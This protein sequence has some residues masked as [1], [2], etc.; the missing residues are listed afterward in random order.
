MSCTN[1][2]EGR[3]RLEG[4]EASPVAQSVHAQG[5]A[6]QIQMDLNE[7]EKPSCWKSDAHPLAQE[8]LHRKHLL[9]MLPDENGESEHHSAHREQPHGTNHHQE[10]PS[11]CHH[12]QRHGESLQKDFFV[13]KQN[14]A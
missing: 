8:T 11:S 13:A 4:N 14:V 3:G 6:L 1:G 7:G 2:Y 12:P 10:N 5:T 9:L